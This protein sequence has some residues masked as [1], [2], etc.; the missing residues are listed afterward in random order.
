M[1]W[2]T[3]RVLTKNLKELLSEIEAGTYADGDIDNPSS[4][5]RESWAVGILTVL[6]SLLNE[7]GLKEEVLSIGSYNEIF[8]YPKKKYKSFVSR[9]KTIL[10]VAEKLISDYDAENKKETPR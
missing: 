2:T 3:I 6:S 4:R 8:E 7:L 10:E 9:A 5:F 1:D